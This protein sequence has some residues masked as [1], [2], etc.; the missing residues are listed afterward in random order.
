MSPS[1]SSERA[2]LNG[3]PTASDTYN[4]ADQGTDWPADAFTAMV[5]GH[6]TPNPIGQ[7]ALHSYAGDGNME[8]ASV[9]GPFSKQESTTDLGIYTGAVGPIGRSTPE[10]T[11]EPTA[12][13]SPR[14]G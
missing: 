1:P 10:A 8:A 3:T 14:N 9:F 13:D 4:P 12:P 6:E 11:P 2:N 7:P 5:A